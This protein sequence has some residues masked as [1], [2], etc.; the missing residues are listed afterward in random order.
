[1]GNTYSI[2]GT[3]LTSQGAYSGIYYAKN[4]IGGNDT[5]TVRTVKSGGEISMVVAEFSGVDT[6]SPLDR[7]AGATGTG[8][9]PSSGN[10]TPSLAG[11]LAIGSGTHNGTTVTTAGTGFTMVAIATETSNN[12]Q[13]LAMEYQ[14]LTGT[15]QT[16]ATFRLGAS[17]AWTQNGALFKHK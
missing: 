13:P 2:A 6:I 5:I 8:S 16:A 7:T 15:P 4:V 12:R 14:V 11:D 10:M 9:T 17:I 3:V 1:M